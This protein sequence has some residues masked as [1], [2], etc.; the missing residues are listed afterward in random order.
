LWAAELA[1]EL[2][3]TLAWM[4]SREVFR[5]VA[6]SVAELATYEWDK[7]APVNIKKGIATQPSAAD[8]RPAGWREFGP[9]RVRGI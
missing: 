3:S 4:S 2:G 5:A 7:L 8:G 6:P 9:P 1:R